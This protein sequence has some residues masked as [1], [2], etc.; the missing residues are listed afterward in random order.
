MLE[1]GDTYLGVATDHVI[2]YLIEG[3]NEPCVKRFASRRQGDTA[4]FLADVRE[5]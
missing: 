1:N 3:S 4:L 2:V 5:L